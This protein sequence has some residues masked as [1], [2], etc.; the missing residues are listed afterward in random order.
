MLTFNLFRIPVSVHWMFFLLTAFLG[1]L[2]GALEVGTPEAFKGVL[3]FMIAAFISIMVHELGHALTGLAMGAKFTQIHLGGMGGVAIFPGASFTRPKSILVTAAGPAA[4]I[5]LALIFS[6]VAA[7]TEN[8]TLSNY[9]LRAQFIGTMV[10][11]NIFWSAF[12]LCPIMPLD[13]G[14]ILRDTLGPKR[15][16]VSSIIS[17]VFVAILSVVIWNWTHSIYNIFI[18][19]L[20]G[21][22]NWQLLK[23]QR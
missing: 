21:M 16:K 2:F 14:Q 19:F 9:P 3:V 13:G 10:F 17:L 8:Q 5:I 15:I 12:N 22:H 20:L 11:I 7:N 6:A 1:G 18:M 4:S 23:E